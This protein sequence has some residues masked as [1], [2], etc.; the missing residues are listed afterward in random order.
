MYDVVQ[1]WCS[2]GIEMAMIAEVPA[3]VLPAQKAVF[4]EGSKMLWK[5]LMTLALG[6]SPLSLT[7]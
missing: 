4:M 1:S 6:G 3:L 7:T 2:E 5:G